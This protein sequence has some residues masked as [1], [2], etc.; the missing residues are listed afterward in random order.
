MDALS[1]I[2]IWLRTT[3]AHGTPMPGTFGMFSPLQQNNPNALGLWKPYF[4][5]R[6]TG[7]INNNTNSFFR[8]VP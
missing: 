3:T 1:V 5:E 8:N 2:S 6:Y 4:F 7:T